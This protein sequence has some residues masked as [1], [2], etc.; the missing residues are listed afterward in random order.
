MLSIYVYRRL[1]ISALYAL[2][3]TYFVTMTLSV[4]SFIRSKWEDAISC[5][6]KTATP[7]FGVDVQAKS[8]LSNEK[9]TCTSMLH[10][11]LVICANHRYAE[12]GW[13]ENHWLVPYDI[14]TVLGMVYIVGF[15]YLEFINSSPPYMRQWMGSALLQI[16]ACRLFGTR[17]SSK[18][19]LGYS[20]LD[21]INKLQWNFN[22]NFINENAY[23]NIVCEMA[24][25]LSRGRWIYYAFDIYVQID[26]GMEAWTKASSY[27][28]MFTIYMK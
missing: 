23:E 21:L 2:H 27:S 25:I 12:P 4:I 26:C 8:V 14:T 10:Y 15:A 20:Q 13:V 24:A 18:P 3:K 17:P 22:H 28:L 7:I 19:M 11:R 9:Y 6:A 16:T 1:H 5:K